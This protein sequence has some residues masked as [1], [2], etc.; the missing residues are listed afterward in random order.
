MIVLA[1]RNIKIFFRDRSNV[2]FSILVV[3]FTLVL[4]IFFLGDKLYGN[5]DFANA[6]PLMEKWKIAGILSTTS[7][8]TTFSIF[9]ILVNDR[10]QKVEKDFHSTPVTYGKRVAGY[11]LSTFLV[12]F[13]MTMVT[14]MIAQAYLYLQYGE[15]FT[16]IEFLS[17]VGITLLSVSSS[18][19]MMFLLVE[20]FRS[21]MAYEVTVSFLGSLISLIAGIYVPMGELPEFVQ[22]IGMIFP[23]SHGA[24]LFR[25]VMMRSEMAKAFRGVSVEAMQEFEFTMG[26]VFDLSN[27]SL[28]PTVSIGYLIVSIFVF[29]I[30]AVILSK[31]K[32]K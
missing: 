21:P 19:A 26:N 11:L 23:G 4:Y 13:L 29:Y 6:Q 32:Q 12:G 16:G 20:L 22:Y 15:L 8:T 27:T 3:L 31:R 10:A 28:S 5:L 7:L 2:F 30:L 24:L 18:T 1:K 25:Q 14:F 9:G 17:I